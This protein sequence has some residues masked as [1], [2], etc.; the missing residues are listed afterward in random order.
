MLS[1]TNKLY[2]QVK[3]RLSRTEKAPEGDIE[4][5]LPPLSDTPGPFAGKHRDKQETTPLTRVT[6]YP[7]DLPRLPSPRVQS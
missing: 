6:V 3:A 7:R 2:N 1:M 5:G 4:Q